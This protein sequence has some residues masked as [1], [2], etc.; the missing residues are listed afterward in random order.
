MSY[1]SGDWFPI[2]VMFIVIVGIATTANQI[3]YD[4]WTCAFKRCVSITN[5]K[6]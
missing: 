2:L 1:K 4:D 3:L 6:K 5:I